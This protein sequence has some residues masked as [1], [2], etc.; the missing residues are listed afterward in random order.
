[1]APTNTKTLTLDGNLQQVFAWDMT[2]SGLYDNFTGDRPSVCV[3]Q[4]IFGLTSTTGTSDIYDINFVADTN[5][6]IDLLSAIVPTTHHARQ[7][8]D[9]Y[10]LQGVRVVSPTKGIYISEGHKIINR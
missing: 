2:V 4:T 3:G 8:H 10:T 7:Q 5:S 1:M 9:T 6:Y